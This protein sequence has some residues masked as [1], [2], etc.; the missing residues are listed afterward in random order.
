MQHAKRHSEKLPRVHSAPSLVAAGRPEALVV[1]LLAEVRC[2]CRESVVTRCYLC[3]FLKPRLHDTTG[4]TTG[5]TVVNVRQ[6]TN[7]RCSFNQLTNRYDSRP[8]VYTIQPVVNPVVKR[9]SQP[10]ECLYT[11]Y[12]RLSNRIDNRL[13]RVNG[14]KFS[15]SECTAL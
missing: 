8:A 6:R 4:L 5:C 3:V 13:Y 9:V 14:A 15:L 11:R 7:S 10:V 2:S 12:N 1:L